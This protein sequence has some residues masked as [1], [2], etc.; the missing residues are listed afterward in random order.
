MNDAVLQAPQ[1]AE[2]LE[3]SLAAV[4]WPEILPPTG[5]RG[6]WSRAL[7]G[8]SAGQAVREAGRAAIRAAVTPH[9]IDP[10]EMIHEAYRNLDELADLA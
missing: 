9:I 7:K 1:L 5:L 10:T 3:Q 2:E 8:H 6:L 4:V